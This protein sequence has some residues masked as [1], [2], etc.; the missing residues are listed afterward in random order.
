MK[1][2]AIPRR[3]LLASG[4]GTACVGALGLGASLAARPAQAADAPFPNRPLTLIVPYP[5]GG[6][7]DVFARLIADQLTRKF[8]QPV[9][10]DNKP[11]AG[12]LIGL[13]QLARAPADGHTLA[14]A[15]SSYTTAAA[16]QPKL[17]FDPMKDIAPVARINS[18]ALVVNK[19][20]YT[21]TLCE[22]LI[23]DCCVLRCVLLCILNICLE[24]S[25][26]EDLV[27][28]WTIARFPTCSAIC[29]WK[30]YASAGALSSRL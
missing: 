10:V 25:S 21:A 6:S 18:S 23:S 4:L 12:G 15:S 28:S 22:L 1:Q 2:A 20:H 3:A 26:C 13:G 16:L 29:I 24:S 19:N 8:G 14:L 9:V 5:P 17:P 7:N 30:N 27:K 11:G